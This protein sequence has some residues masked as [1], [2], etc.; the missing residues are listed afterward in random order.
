MEQNVKCVLPLHNSSGSQTKPKNTIVCSPTPRIET[1]PF[2]YVLL[3]VRSSKNVHKKTKCVHLRAVSYWAPPAIA[4]QSHVL[5]CCQFKM[6]IFLKHSVFNI[7]NYTLV[8]IY[9][10]WSWTHWQIIFILVGLSGIFIALSTHW[11]IISSGSNCNVRTQFFFILTPVQI[12]KY[13]T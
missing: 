8:Y 5:S 3:L 1:F 13:G 9:T 2:I 11:P 4:F 6:C 10:V 12:C 7:A